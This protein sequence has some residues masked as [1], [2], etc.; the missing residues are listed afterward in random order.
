MTD[1]N[2]M[3]LLAKDESLSVWL[4]LVLY[5]NQAARYRN[6]EFCRAVFTE[7]HINSWYEKMA[8]ERVS[9]SA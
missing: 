8:V 9:R 1:D 4:G 5:S 7:I 3:Q 6:L 2:G